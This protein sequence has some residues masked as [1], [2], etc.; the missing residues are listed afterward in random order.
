MKT[1]FD[2]CGAIL[3]LAGCVL[4][5]RPLTRDI[6]IYALVLNALG[7]IMIIATVFSRVTAIL[8]TRA[9]AFGKE[10]KKE[11]KRQNEL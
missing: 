1:H 7:A 2:I 8:K 10:L 11:I 9:T 5:Q 4:L 6:H 3:V